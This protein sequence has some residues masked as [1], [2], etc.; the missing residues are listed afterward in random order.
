MT[1]SLYEFVERVVIPGPNTVERNQC[2]SDFVH[3]AYERMKEMYKDNCCIKIPDI[4][5]F[6][7]ARGIYSYS[8]FAWEKGELVRSVPSLG[9]KYGIVDNIVPRANGGGWDFEVVVRHSESKTNYAHDSIEKADMPK[10]ILDLAKTE[11]KSK[12]PILGEC[13]A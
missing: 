1:E 5:T 7:N 12:C 10:E 11:L 2:R 9:G 4:V 13:D 6:A 8:S 3:A